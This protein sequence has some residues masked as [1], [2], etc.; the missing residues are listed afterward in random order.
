MKK[1]PRGMRTE[2]VR[3][4]RNYGLGGAFSPEALVF[5]KLEM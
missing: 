4:S 2:D 1:R 3:V 5:I